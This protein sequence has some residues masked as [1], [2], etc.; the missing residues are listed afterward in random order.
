[1][2]KYYFCQHLVISIKLWHKDKGLS[3]NSFVCF[4][5][6]TDG[7]IHDLFN[8]TP[9]HQIRCQISHGFVVPQESSDTIVVFGF[10]FFYITI[11][12]MLVMFVVFSPQLEPLIP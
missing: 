10:F 7:M 3:S 1:M 9:N 2:G 4:G 8:W 5:C 6:K 12:M 11:L